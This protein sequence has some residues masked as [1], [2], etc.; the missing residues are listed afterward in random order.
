MASTARMLDVQTAPDPLSLGALFSPP[1][2]L[3]QRVRW[4]FLAALTFVLVGVG[5]QGVLAAQ[6]AGTAWA[7]ALVAPMGL[8][9]VWVH[10]YLRRGYTL[11]HD[12][13]AITL[14]VLL[15]SVQPV[16]QVVAWL[17]VGTAWMR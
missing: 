13:A 3:L 5:L 8:Y 12:A 17:I 15:A 16:P 1:K 6:A 4:L 11:G 10:G 7:V 2:G 9:A 14:L